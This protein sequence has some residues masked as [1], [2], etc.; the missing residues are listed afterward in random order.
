M[1]DERAP[2]LLSGPKLEDKGSKSISMRDENQFSCSIPANTQVFTFLDASNIL[3]IQIL[4]YHKKKKSGLATPSL[5]LKCWSS[6][7]INLQK[8]SLTILHGCNHSRGY[9]MNAMVQMDGIRGDVKM[10]QL[11]GEH[12]ACCGQRIP[13]V[14]VD[15]VLTLTTTDSG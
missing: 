10:G 12:G 6:D 5:L 3:A 4:D 11:V 9:S 7:S 13:R 2:A 14:L 1:A 8:S 15:M